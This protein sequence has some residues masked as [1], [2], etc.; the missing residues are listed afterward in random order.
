MSESN[1]NAKATHTNVRALGGLNI[2]GKHR[3]NVVFIAPNR[4]LTLAFVLFESPTSQDRIKYNRMLIFLPSATD[5]NG[6][7]VFQVRSA[8]IPDKYKHP[9]Y[10]HNI[11]ILEVSF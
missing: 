8:V 7:D 10:T 2:D 4:V 1:H 5:T 9:S 6:L 3:S 11:A